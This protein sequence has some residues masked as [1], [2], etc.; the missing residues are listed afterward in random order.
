MV[1]KRQRIVPSRR[2][3]SNKLV[4]ETENPPPM[5]QGK[6]VP[7]QER[8][9]DQT[10]MSGLEARAE[11]RMFSKSC[12]DAGEFSLFMDLENKGTMF[13]S[14][15]KNGHRE[16]RKFVDSTY[17]DVLPVDDRCSLDLWFVLPMLGDELWLGGQTRLHISAL[18]VGC[19]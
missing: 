1:T 13:Q 17:S 7:K 11:T 2:T 9:R 6:G 3:R 15:L 14:Q 5:W 4:G 19:W 16:S 8:E 12:K 18:P 10:T